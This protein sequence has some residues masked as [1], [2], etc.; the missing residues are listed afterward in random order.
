MPW[1]VALAGIPFGLSVPVSTSGSILISFNEDK[2]K[3]VGTLPVRLG[4]KTARYLNIAVLVI[5]YLTSSLI[6]VP[7]YFNPVMLVVFL[8]AKTLVQA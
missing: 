5:I 8:A 3:D 7:R 4:E 6:F 2:N 1:Y